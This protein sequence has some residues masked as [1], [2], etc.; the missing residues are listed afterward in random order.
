MIRSPCGAA[1]VRTIR[2][3]RENM[4][5]VSVLWGLGLLTAIAASLLWYGNVSYSLAHND[6]ELAS[7]NTTVE[8]GINRAIDALLDPRPGRRWKADGAAQSFEFGG[9]SIK[10]SIQDELG[11]I[12]LNQAEASLLVSLLQ[13]AGLDPDSASKLADKIVDW[14]TATPLKQLNGAKESD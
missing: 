11:K 9:V 10:V 1:D 14:R 7:I 2:T 8:A 5:V 12:D 6:L 4:P 13:S 3:G